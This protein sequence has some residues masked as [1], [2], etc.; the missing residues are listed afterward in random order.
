MFTNEGKAM[1]LFKSDPIGI[2]RYMI[3][4]ELRE[5]GH[6]KSQLV[7]DQYFQRRSAYEHQIEQMEKVCL[8]NYKI[9]PHFGESFFFVDSKLCIIVLKLFTR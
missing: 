6:E 9:F 3:E 7:L 4:M 2:V 1:D 5:D 8:G